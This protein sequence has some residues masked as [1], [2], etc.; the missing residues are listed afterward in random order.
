MARLAV[1]PRSRSEWK[2]TLA[3]PGSE[4]NDPHDFPRRQ[5][6]SDLNPP[7]TPPQP[8][9]V[10]DSS[11]F[12]RLIEPLALEDL[13]DPNAGTPGGYDTVAADDYHSLSFWGTDAEG[14]GINQT[15][16]KET[17][18][19]KRG[20]PISFS[21]SEMVPRGCQAMH[22]F[23]TMLFHY[24]DIAHIAGIGTIIRK[25]AASE[26]G[27]RAKRSL[28]TAD[29][30]PLPTG[31]SSRATQPTH[32]HHVRDHLPTPARRRRRSCRRLSCSSHTLL[33]DPSLPL[34][35]V[36]PWPTGCGC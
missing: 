22:R 16:G 7:Y 10:S 34:C 1:S 19:R 4:L 28:E 32:R 8:M 12:E 31:R 17:R 20:F 9:V 35:Q 33:D 23:I 36:R 18:Q 5:P 26:A 6:V 25:W 2:E 3:W 24:A 14:T 29:V 30:R 11:T 13:E 21:F 27:P 15:P